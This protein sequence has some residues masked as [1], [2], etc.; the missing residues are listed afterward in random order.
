MKR[1][2]FYFLFALSFYSCAP[3]DPK[4][5]AM[6]YCECVKNIGNGSDNQECLEMA[7]RHKELLGDSKDK[8][9]KYADELLNCTNVSK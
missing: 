1:N 8:Q 6:E 9:Q 5:M 4:D 3:T 2:P 7:K